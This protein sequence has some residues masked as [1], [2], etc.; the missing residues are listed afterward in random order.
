MYIYKQFCKLDFV[1][2]YFV[3][4]VTEDKV[5]GTPIYTTVGGQSKCPGETY[6]SRRQSRV[7]ISRL[8]HRCGAHKNSICD[9]TTLG[10]GDTALFGVQIQNLSP[11]GM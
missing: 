4:R 8:I 9:E 2:D 7:Q 1:G 6:T 10:P 5:F 3:V 11:T